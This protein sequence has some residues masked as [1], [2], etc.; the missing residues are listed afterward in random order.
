MPIYTYRCK[1]CNT[2]EEVIL[3]ISDRDNIR[4]HCDSE[5]QRIIEV[6]R[7]V[8]MKQTGKGMALDAL[9]S[10]DTA[11]MKS[12]QKQWAAQGLEEPAKTIF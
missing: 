11:H 3:P 6:P 1:Q 7:L 9:N 5:M 2:E 8:L 12:T 4:T 10:K